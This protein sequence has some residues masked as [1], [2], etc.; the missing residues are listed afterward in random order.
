MRD[1]ITWRSHLRGTLGVSSR[2]RDTGDAQWFVNLIDNTRLDH[3]Y[4]VFGEV[5][6]GLDVA[7][8]ILEG[9]VIA[10]VEVVR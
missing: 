5:T 2:G 1:E 10:H 9:D 8:R 6:S 7:E 3:D 4:T